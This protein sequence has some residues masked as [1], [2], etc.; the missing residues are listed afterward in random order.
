MDDRH[1]G[2]PWRGAAAGLVAGVAFLA[3]MALDMR[4]TGEP[5]N[6]LRMLAGL[7]PRGDRHWRWL[8]T[9]IHFANSAAVGVAFLQVRGRLPGPGWLRGLLFIQGENLALWPLVAAIDR[10][11]PA[12]RAGRLPRFNRPLPFAQEVLRHAAFGL[13]LGAV[14]DRLAGRA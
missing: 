12:I 5:T 4:A 11:H 3:A 14:A 10:V 8:G 6:D 1:D 13:V 9:A 7:A 2:I